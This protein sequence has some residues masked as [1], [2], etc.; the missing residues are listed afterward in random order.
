MLVVALAGLAMGGGVWSYRMWHLSRYYAYHAQFNREC[1]G[2]RRHI[3]DKEEIAGPRIPEPTM[4]ALLAL[5]AAHHASLA[6]K[7]ERAARYPWLSLEPDPPEPKESRYLGDLHN[8]DVP[9]LP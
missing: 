8:V 5:E 9:G 3:V 4:E 2:V 6:R 1:V 7:Y